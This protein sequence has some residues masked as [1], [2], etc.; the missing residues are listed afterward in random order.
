MPA[1]EIDIDRIEPNPDQPRLQMDEIALE[2]LASSIR[3]HGVL[4]PSSSSPGNGA[5]PPP[6]AP[7]F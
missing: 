7:D 4:Q 2:Q 5:S 6:S 3:E 1:S